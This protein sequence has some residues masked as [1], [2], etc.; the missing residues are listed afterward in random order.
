MDKKKTLVHFLAAAAMVFMAFTL[1]GIAGGS[2]SMQPTKNEDGSFSYDGL[3]RLLFAFDLC[4]LTFA[5]LIVILNDGMFTEWLPSAGII[6]G[7]TLVGFFLSF[8]PIIGFILSGLYGIWWLIASIRSLAASW[9][10]NSSAAS[11]LMAICRIVMAITLLS[12]LGIWALLPDTAVVAKEVVEV[13]TGIG[14]LAIAAAVALCIE[15]FI[16]LKYCD[17]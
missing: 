15:G 1:F 6:V 8:S 5:G 9:G 2:I 11:V 14:I 16:W 17:Y 10:E 13:Y 4:I 12:F 7:L 3:V